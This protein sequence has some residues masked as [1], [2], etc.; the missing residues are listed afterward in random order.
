MIFVI[1]KHHKV[2]DY[3]YKT[4]EIDPNAL[5]KADFEAYANNKIYDLLHEKPNATFIIIHTKKGAIKDLQKRFKSKTHA[6]K[7]KYD[8]YWIE[9]NDLYKINNHTF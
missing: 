4:K 6:P 2:L 7:Q 1:L 8:R 9:F 3:I 5:T